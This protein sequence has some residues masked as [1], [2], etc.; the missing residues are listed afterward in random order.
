MV[1]RKQ[2]FWNEVERGEELWLTKAG[3]TQAGAGLE[4]R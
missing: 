3:G 4:V 2:S 1:F